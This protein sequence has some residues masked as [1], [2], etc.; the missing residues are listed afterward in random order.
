MKTRSKALL[1]TLC[2]V[3][4]VAASVL[5][6]MAYLTSTDEVTNTFTV[7]QVKI[8]L[9]EAKANPDGSLVAN[10]DRV[11]ANEYKLLPGHTY[12]KDPMVT[13]LSGSESSYVKMTVTFSKANE[14][15]AIFAPGGADLTSIFNGYDA[16]KW[17]A[18]GN[19]KDATANTRTYEFWY[20]ETVGAPTADV[21]LDALFD[22]ITVPGTITN[23]QLAT[24]EGMTITVNAYAIQ[25][26]GF[27]N[28]E[29]AWAAFN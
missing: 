27:A 6:T 15:D 26:D 14:L 13:V 3:L 12:N 10:A 4:L 21:A 7:G 20:K 5:G 16:A 17:I 23:E 11:K 22:S 1:L 19:T 24:I 28:A 2:A 9:D 25:A 29:A 8:K 18:K